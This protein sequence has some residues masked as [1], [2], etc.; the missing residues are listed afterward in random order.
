MPFDRLH[1]L[2]YDKVL[3][4]SKLKVFAKDS[5]NVVEMVQFPSCE[6]WLPAFS[7][8]PAMFQKS[9]FQGMSQAG[10]VR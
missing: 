2:P 3:A 1:P 4:L 5:F 10:F 6:N 7:T 9:S 8:F